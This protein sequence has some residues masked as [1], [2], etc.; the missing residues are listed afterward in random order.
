ML[1]GD[2]PFDKAAWV[3]KVTDNKSRIKVNELDDH[4]TDFIEL[5]C[6]LNLYLENYRDLRRENQKKI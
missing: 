5:D 3:K 6:V 1:Y 2:H 4:E